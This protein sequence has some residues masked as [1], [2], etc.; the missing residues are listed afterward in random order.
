MAL[1][2]MFSQAV[3]KLE[4]FVKNAGCA[5]T[6]ASPLV[7]YGLRLSASVILA[8]FVPYRLEFD[9]GFWAGI[10]A[11]VVCQPSL[12]SSL[13]KARVPAIGTFVGA[14][15]ILLLTAAFPQNRP[16][17]LLGL[18]LWIGVCGFFASVLRHFA[19]YGAALAG[20]TTAVIFADVVNAPGD[21]FIVAA[22]RTSEICVG[23]V[24]VTV[25]VMLTSVGDG[26]R[27]LAENLSRVAQQTAAGLAD[28]LAI[29]PDTATSRSRR[30][31]LIR[32]VIELEGLIEEAKAEA[33]DL[34]HRSQIL[35]AGT[36]G[37]FS[38]ISAW[39]G[40]A[41]HFNAVWDD[42]GGRDAA[43]LHPMVL[44]ATGGDWI[45]R[46]ECVRESCNAAARQVLAI[47][48]DEVAT[49]LLVDRVAEALLDLQRAANALVLVVAPG[50]ETP[51]ISGSR[52]WLFTPDLLPAA[53]NGLR[54][55]VIVL[56]KPRGPAV[57]Q[58]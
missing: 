28:T 35:H 54:A 48:V 29:G 5:L 1:K 7:L 19:S 43:G 41:N 10:T 33:P 4:G 16:G 39:Q 23:I 26:R 47:P 9:S 14:V 8:L 50:K 36:E 31:D 55:V 21:T 57:R 34:R 46:A 25:V 6:M 17:M 11:T 49:R 56:A 44:D 18:A 38:A 45:D 42:V 51:E 27:R 30:R 37:L 58:W 13:R 12:G 53:V 3:S 32:N 40:I 52:D 20:F 2:A 24:S 22:T 15:A